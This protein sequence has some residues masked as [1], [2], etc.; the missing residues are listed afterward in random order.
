M[1]PCFCIHICVYV[2]FSAIPY[3]LPT[4]KVLVPSDAETEASFSCLA[5]DFSPKVFKITWLKNE[6][7][8]PNKIDEIITNIN[9]RKDENGTTLYSA[10]SFLTV[11]S[12]QWSQDTKFTCKFT[13]K[14]ESGETTTNASTT[15]TSTSPDPIREYIAT[16]SLNIVFKCNLNSYGSASVSV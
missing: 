15:H 6:V 16:F 8:I 12:S 11:K 9:E 5:K 4:L 10:A 1:I 7:E 14:G 3:Q 2:C 13:G